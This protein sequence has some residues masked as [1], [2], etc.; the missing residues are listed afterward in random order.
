MERRESLMT[1]NDIGDSCFRGLTI[2]IHVLSTLSYNVL[3]LLHLHDE[4]LKFCILEI[5]SPFVFKFT[6]YCFYTK[7]RRLTYKYETSM[8]S[9][10]KSFLQ[11]LLER[12]GI[13]LN[14]ILGMPSFLDKK[15]AINLLFFNLNSMT[16]E[17]ILQKG[18][19]W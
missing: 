4:R 10:N 12:N 7:Q 11:S 17:R 14:G 1:M 15:I 18:I 2:H 19:G 6:V 8:T 3:R 13:Q 5:C 9:K 16:S